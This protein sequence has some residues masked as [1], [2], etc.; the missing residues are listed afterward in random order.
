MIGIEVRGTILYMIL[1]G[2]GVDH[3]DDIVP[4]FVV[5]QGGNR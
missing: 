2:E 3:Y 5:D 4:F 1:R